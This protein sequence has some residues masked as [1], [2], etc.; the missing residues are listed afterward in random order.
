[1]YSFMVNGSRRIT[2]NPIEQCRTKANTKKNV[3]FSLNI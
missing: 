1:M 3:D 2:D